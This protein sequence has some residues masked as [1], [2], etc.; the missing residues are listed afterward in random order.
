MIDMVGGLAH[1]E[2][3]R[4]GMGVDALRHE[5]VPVCAV[6][7]DLVRIAGYVSP[8]PP[9][10][11]VAVGVSCDPGEY[12]H[13]SGLGRLLRYFDGRRPALPQIV[14]ERVI[15]I[16]VIR[17]GGVHVSEVVH[18]EPR[19]QIAEAGPRRTRRTSP[20]A[21]NLVVGER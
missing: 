20:T 10:G 9:D 12:V 15:D 7:R 13:F 1:C 5:H 6:R 18:R 8:I 21:E 19:E 3:W 11:D 14:R 16:S 4:D 17:P 2:E